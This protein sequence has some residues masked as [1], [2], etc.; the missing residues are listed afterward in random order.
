MTPDE[1]IAALSEALSRLTHHPKNTPMTPC[2]AGNCAMHQDAAVHH[3]PERVL[4]SSPRIGDASQHDAIHEAGTL[5]ATSVNAAVKQRHS[6]WGAYAPAADAAALDLIAAGWIM[7]GKGAANE[8]LRKT[9]LDQQHRI[10][11]LGEHIVRKEAEIDAAEAFRTKFLGILFGLR[12]GFTRKSE[13]ARIA[14]EPEPTYTAEQILKWLDSMLDR[15]DKAAEK[16]KA[17]SLT[18]K[19][20][21]EQQKHSAPALGGQTDL[22]EVAS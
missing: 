1:K 12:D 6:G 19:P 3:T 20:S 9:V 2:I 14:D 10:R 5:I 11:E 22:F 13:A 18:A 8:R 16:A 15:S 4:G 17:K 21:E 7:P